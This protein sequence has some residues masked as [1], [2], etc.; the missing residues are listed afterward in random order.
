MVSR[1]VTSSLEEA[2]P[3]WTCEGQNFEPYD[4]KEAT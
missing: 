1:E 3:L 4:E 2:R